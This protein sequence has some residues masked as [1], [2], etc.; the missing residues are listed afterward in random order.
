MVGD[1]EIGYDITERSSIEG[2]K[3][4]VKKYL[5]SYSDSRIQKD[6]ER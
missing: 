5:K 6:S 4:V 2:K 3:E 1:I